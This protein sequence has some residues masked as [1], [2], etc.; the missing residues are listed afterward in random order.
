[1]KEFKILQNGLS[2]DTKNKIWYILQ[3]LEAIVRFA[4]ANFPGR[5]EPAK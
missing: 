2:Y 1:M 3:M 4:I 5:E